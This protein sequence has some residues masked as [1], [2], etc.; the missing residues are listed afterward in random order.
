MPSIELV[1]GGLQNG[2]D[3]RK[4]PANQLTAMTNATVARGI[5]E[6]GPRQ[7]AKWARAGAHAADRGYGLFYAEFESRREFIAIVQPNGSTTAT[8]FRVDPISGTY[9][10]ITGG[11]GLTVA[12]SEALDTWQFHQFG[13]WIYAM[14]QAAGAWMRRVGGAGTVG[15]PG[16]DALNEWRPFQPEYL[17]GTSV[18]AALERPLYPQY[19]LGAGTVGSWVAD[20]PHWQQLNASPEADGRILVIDGTV[21]NDPA[22]YFSIVF[23]EELDW[24]QVDC[25]FI[26]LGPESGFDDIVYAPASNGHFWNPV[27]T[28]LPIEDATTTLTAVWA[29]SLGLLTTTRALKGGRSV[30]RLDISGL[31]AAS[32]DRIRRLVMRV[33]GAT[34]RPNTYAIRIYLGGRFAWGIAGSAPKTEYAACYAKQ[35]TG[36]RSQAVRTEVPAG[37]IDGVAFTTGMALGGSWMGLSVESSD[38]LKAQGFDRV[39]F[40]RR[41]TDG[42][43]GWKLLADV[44]NEGSPATVDRRNETEVRA[45]PSVPLTFE[46]FGAAI[47]PSAMGRWKQHAILGVGQEV[48]LSYEGLPRAFVPSNQFNFTVPEVLE[49]IAGATFF[50]SPGRTEALQAIVAEDVLFLLASTSIHAVIGD[51]IRQATPPRILPRS[52]GPLSR[53]AA[54]GWNGGAVVGSADGLWWYRVSRA[55]AVGSN[56]AY[57]VVELT[58]TIRASWARLIGAAGARLVVTVHDDEIWAFCENRYLRFTRETVGTGRREWEEGLV[59]SVQD[60][61]PTMAHGLRVLTRDGG[62]RRIGV[63][64]TQD[65]TQPVNWSVTTGW[66]AGQRHRTYAVSFIADGDPEIFVDIQDSLGG[67]E[68]TS[69]EPDAGRFEVPFVNVLPGHLWRV[70]ASG[71]VGVDRITDLR[72]HFEEQQ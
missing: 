62:I 50:L 5:W 16:Y 69:L 31:S 29:A 70:R 42:G 51:S 47:K 15:D 64:L 36:E 43:A 72:V 23:P 27:V 26:E 52:R 41:A 68:A 19:L 39:Q 10:A 61:A 24:T 53:R 57:E 55:F 58:Q 1:G 9:T 6:G 18:G 14:S 35:A 33:S 71:V 3:E 8:A 25:L 63:D 7:S 48:Y 28:A 20:G 13:E 37:T 22:S 30:H 46:A 40:F 45:L 34:F 49:P 12:G 59:E 60:V 54:V 65:G 32:R 2:I 4:V 21:S 56:D 44:A 67:V 11:T 66:V 38:I 17:V